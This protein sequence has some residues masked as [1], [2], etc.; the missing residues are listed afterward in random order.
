M[1]DVIDDFFKTGKWS[2]KPL[3]L[4]LDL[5]LMFKSHENSP[6]KVKMIKSMRSFHQIE[7]NTN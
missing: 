3:T 6:L 5:P 4:I 1:E 2:K 7:L